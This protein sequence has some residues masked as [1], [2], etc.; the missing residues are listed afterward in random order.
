[1]LP[2]IEFL[3]ESGNLLIAAVGLWLMMRSQERSNAIEPM[4]LKKS[5]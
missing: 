4:V 2:L 1:M 3:F 5:T